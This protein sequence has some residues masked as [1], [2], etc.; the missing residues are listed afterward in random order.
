MC[1]DL[2]PNIHCKLVKVMPQRV[3]ISAHVY[4]WFV[5]WSFMNGFSKIF[6]RLTIN[7]KCFVFGQK[8]FKADP[9]RET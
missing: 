1:N 8:C 4:F 7:I 3:G 5:T 9:Q 2:S 6:S